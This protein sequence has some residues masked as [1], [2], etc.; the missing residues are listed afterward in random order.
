MEGDNEELAAAARKI[1]P[2][3]ANGN[4]LLCVLLLGNVAVNALLSI[5]SAEI[6]G[7][8]VGFVSSTMLIVI[9]G[10]IIPQALCARYALQIGCRVIPLVR[11]ITIL[12]YPIAAPMAWV[13]NKALGNEL[14]TT[15]SSAE[16]R[17]LLEIHV[18]EGRVDQETADAMQGALKYKEISVR[19]VMTPLEH[20]FML[21][22][23]EKLSFETI[24]TIFKT[25]YSRIPIFE[26]SV[27]N[28][29]GLLFVKD[30]I[31]I[32]PEDGQYDISAPICHVLILF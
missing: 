2:V 6:F 20:S 24:A 9:F 8:T 31:F 10:E 7:G 32:D 19:E 26:V 21:N 17:K 5:L 22:V 12:V 23:D 13:L 27:N 28:V 29:I 4:L 30:L 3:R 1:Y 11:V 25:G 14:A 18:Q 16:M 15:Y